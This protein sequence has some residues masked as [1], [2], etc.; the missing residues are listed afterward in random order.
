MITKRQSELRV[1]LQRRH[2]AFEKRGS[3]AVVVVENRNV[4]ASRLP[5]TCPVISGHTYRRTVV[6]IDNSWVV[7]RRNDFS[8]RLV[9]RIV[10]D[11]D[12]R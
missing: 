9:W 11:D 4:L 10:S 6:T 12:L 2:E 1:S 7:K 3:K 5:K 8:Q